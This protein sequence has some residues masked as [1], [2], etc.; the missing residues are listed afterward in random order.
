M[1]LAYRKS[2]AGNLLKWSDL[3]LGLSLKVKRG[4]ASLKV[5]ITH[6]L[7][8]VEVCSVKPTYRKSWAGNLLM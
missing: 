6:L 2:W 1:K 3:T 4:Y 5:P 7:L 8:I